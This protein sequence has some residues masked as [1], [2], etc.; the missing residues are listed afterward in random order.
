M[1]AVAPPPA[2]SSW[3]SYPSIVSDATG[4]LRNGISVIST[5]TTLGET[6]AKTA[7]VAK[8]VLGTIG[9]VANTYIGAK[10]AVGAVSDLTQATR[11]EGKVEGVLKL[12]VGLALALVGIGMVLFFAGLNL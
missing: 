7:A 12:V 3:E 2:S 8:G 1:A 5:G 10:M 4:A 9:G 11:L 6:A